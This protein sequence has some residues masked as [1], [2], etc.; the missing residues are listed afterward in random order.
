MNIVPNSTEMLAFTKE[1]GGTAERL[2]HF[3][4]RD[5]DRTDTM[6]TDKLRSYSA[7]KREIIPGV[8]H[9]SHKGLNNR[10]E[11]SHQPVR[12]REWIMKCFK[13][14]RHLQRFVSIQDPITNLFQIPR[15]YISSGHHRELRAGA[16]SLWAKIALL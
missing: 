9:R 15:H 11:N 10:A 13:S 12:R 7:A 16:M 4:G 3:T 8:E 6:I 14:Q 5:P 1:R 2:S